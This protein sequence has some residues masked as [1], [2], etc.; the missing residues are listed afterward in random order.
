MREHGTLINT[1]L[2][3]GAGRQQNLRSRFNGFSHAFTLIELL[4]VIAII[5]I[6]AAMLLPALA[7]SKEKAQRT[8]CKSNIRQVSLGAIMYA[9]DNADKFPNAVWD[10]ALGHTHAVWLPTNS[11][12]YFVNSV[13]VSTNC[14][15]CPNLVKI[16]D[17]I[18]YKKDRVR[19][20]YFCLWGVATEVDTRPRNVN[21][22]ASVPWPWDSPKKT[23]DP[24]TPYTLLLADIISY[25]IDNFENEMNVTIAP[26]TRG[27]LRHT[28]VPPGSTDPVS[29]GSEG[30]NI[31]FVDGSVLW[32]KQSDMHQR[33]T[34]WNPSPVQND[35]IGFW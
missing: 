9:G 5:A 14:F 18:W 26:H 12:D 21:Y 7:R 30:G 31:G 19:M 25:G 32:R 28:P 20:G 23:T 3:R 8:V 17:W 13:R 4:V 6:L 24:A 1:P 16:G 27:G 34:F 22:G 35:Y 11:Y 2:R 15:S 29:I 33:W 10:P